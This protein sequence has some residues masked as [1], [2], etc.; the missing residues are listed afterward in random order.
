LGTVEAL[1]AV[2]VYCSNDEIIVK[3]LDDDDAGSR[4]LIYDTQGQ[5][6]LQTAVTQSSE[7]RLRIP[8][9]DGIYIFRMEG[10]R[11]FTLKFS[12]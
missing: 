7:M 8:L 5:L 10:K 6:L 11:V 2:S 12:R 3:G 1:E 4:L 9:A